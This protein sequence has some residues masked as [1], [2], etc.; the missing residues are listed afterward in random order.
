MIDVSARIDAAPVGAFQW[1]IVM[2]C[3]LVALFDG[4]DIQAMALVA[5]TLRNDWGLD[6]A[7]LGPFIMARPAATHAARAPAAPV[8][9]VPQETL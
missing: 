5:P 9:P 7:V 4:F 6:V 1:R 2:L 3:A 8:I